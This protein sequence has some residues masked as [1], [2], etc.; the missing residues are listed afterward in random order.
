MKSALFWAGI[1]GEFIELGVLLLFLALQMVS[2]Y[3]I[4]LDLIGCDVHSIYLFIYT[5]DVYLFTPVK[6][7][8]Q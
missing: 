2:I 3:F 1:C 8:S 7:L 4:Y 6:D 5:V